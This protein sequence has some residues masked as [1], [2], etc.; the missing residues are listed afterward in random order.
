MYLV[1]NFK[2]N[3]FYISLF[4]NKFA[5]NTMDIA[6]YTH[7]LIYC[8]SF[9]CM[10]VCVYVSMCMFFFSVLK[11]KPAIIVVNLYVVIIMFR[12]IR[13]ETIDKMCIFQFNVFYALIRWFKSIKCYLLLFTIVDTHR[14]LLDTH[15]IE[16]YTNK[17]YTLCLW[18]YQKYW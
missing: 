15:V 11:S 10:Y 1:Y 13:C 12:S 7:S 17:S 4:T 2:R 16:F 18:Q 9:G 6:C 14:Y 8:Y 5:I 3:V